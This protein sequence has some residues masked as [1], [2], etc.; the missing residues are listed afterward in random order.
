M[1]EEYKSNLCKLTNKEE[2]YFQSKIFEIQKKVLTFGDFFK[3]VGL[4]HR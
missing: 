4:K 3:Y 2:D 1:L